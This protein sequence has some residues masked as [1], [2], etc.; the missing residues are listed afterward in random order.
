MRL[1]DNEFGGWGKKPG[2]DFV[3]GLGLILD[4]K[5]FAG[6]IQ[7]MVGPELSLISHYIYEYLPSED[8]SWFGTN[9]KLYFPNLVSYSR[10]QTPI[11]L[12]SLS[13]LS[14]C[15]I[16]YGLISFPFV[17][18][19]QQH[20]SW[21]RN[22]FFFLCERTFWIKMQGHS[23][24]WHFFRFLLFSLKRE[25]YTIYEKWFWRTIEASRAMEAVTKPRMELIRTK[26]LM[27]PVIS[28]RLS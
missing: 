14:L 15:L 28:K 21:L 22:A 2:F 18:T 7:I 20:V 16:S 8:W 19:S 1:R 12:F 6:S 17:F 10:C 3:W 25:N 9:V 4:W 5:T 27:I 26:A 11:T 13:F 24:H 23:Y